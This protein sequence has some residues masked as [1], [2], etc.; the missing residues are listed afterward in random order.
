M[1]MS[2]WFEIQKSLMIR[3]KDVFNSYFVLFALLASVG[4]KLDWRIS[5]H[6]YQWTHFWLSGS[7][8]SESY[9]EFKLNIHNLFPVLIDTKSVAKDIWKVIS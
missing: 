6:F 2:G 9:D 8:P 1:V 4:D 7:F 5:S 3:S